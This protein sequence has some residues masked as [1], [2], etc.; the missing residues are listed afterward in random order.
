MRNL[1]PTG[2]A[3]TIF[4]RL[5]AYISGVDK[6]WK[7]NIEAANEDEIEALYNYSFVKQAG[8]TF[9][10]AYITYLKYMGK[11]D[12]GLLRSG[13][14]N[15]S[16]HIDDILF[17]YKTWGEYDDSEEGFEEDFEF[18]NPYKFVFAYNDECDYGYYIYTKDNN[19]QVICSG[20]EARNGLPYYAENFEKLLFQNAFLRYERKY[21]P[22]EHE[23]SASIM[24]YS[25]YL[26][27]YENTNIFENIDKLLKRYNLN[28]VWFYDECHYIVA[29]SSMSVMIRRDR[30]ISGFITGEDETEVR[31]IGLLIENMFK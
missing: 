17:Y 11:Y 22:Y 24:Q 26:E 21:F 14:Y 3:D 12:G 29:N 10:D 6:E 23:I 15:S 9:P 19:E 27:K 2:T 7:D 1:P 20:D 18:T 28:K 5:E 25:V 4:E 13:L 31:E 30:I 8:I 16:P